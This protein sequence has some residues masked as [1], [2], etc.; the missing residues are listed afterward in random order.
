MSE[1]RNNYKKTDIK[2]NL[3]NALRTNYMTREDIQNFLSSEYK[4]LGKVPVNCEKTDNYKVSDRTVTRMINSIKDSYGKQLEINE[5]F[6]TYKLDL[7]D[8]PDTIEE[9]EIQAG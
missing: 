9:T 8:F 6:G 7:Y 2:L 3:I 4:R 1:S 5:E